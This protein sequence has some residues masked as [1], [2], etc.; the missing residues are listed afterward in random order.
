MRAVRPSSYQN[1]GGLGKVILGKEIRK[2]V[3][4]LEKYFND[5]LKGI[6]KVYLE[7]SFKMNNP[8]READD[9][10]RILLYPKKAPSK[11]VFYCNGLSMSIQYESMA[12]KLKEYCL[13][14]DGAELTEDI[15]RKIWGEVQG[16]MYPCLATLIKVDFSKTLDEAENQIGN[17]ILTI[18]NEKRVSIRELAVQ[19]GKDYAGMHRLVNRESLDTTQFKTI[20]EIADYLKVEIDDLYKSN[21]KPGGMEK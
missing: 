19:L 13:K 9:R 18:L 6:A 16:A 17:N 7:Y 8:R 3:A 15:Y 20:L 14:L 11:L 21:K 12:Q 5:Y 10:F 2:E 4:K 1:K